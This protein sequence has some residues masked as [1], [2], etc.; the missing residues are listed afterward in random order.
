MSMVH[1][2]LK[3]PKHTKCIAFDGLPVVTV[4]D[5]KNVS[6]DT[7]YPSE[8]AY[9]HYV[10]EQLRV[11]QAFDGWPKGNRLED[12]SK[13]RYLDGRKPDV[14]TFADGIVS[15]LYTLVVGEVKRKK[16]FSSSSKGELATFLERVLYTQPTREKA[17]GFL[18]DGLQ[19]L[20]MLLRQQTSEIPQEVTVT[21]ILDLR[22][23]GDGHSNAIGKRVLMKLLQ[24]KPEVVGFVSVKGVP[25]GYTLQQFIGRGASSTVYSATDSKEAPCAVKISSREQDAQNEVRILDLLSVTDIKAHVP[26]VLCSRGNAIVLEKLSSLGRAE[27]EPGASHFRQ[28]LA[29]LKIAHT[30]L[31]LCHRDVRVSNW[32]LGGD[33]QTRLVDWTFACT[34]SELCPYQGTLGYGSQSV[35]QAYLKNPSQVAVTPADD[36]ESVV[37]IAYYFVTG[38]RVLKGPEDTSQVYAQN[39]L[40][41]WSGVLQHSPV[42]KGYATLASQNDYTLGGL[43][44]LFPHA[45]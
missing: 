45:N 4:G 20:F 9:Q 5:E 34:E 21:P 30:Q 24:S 14:S 26:A 44:D 22:E 42:W 13:D 6:L 37:R 23:S 7:D 39:S 33:D 31:K 36:L 41:F 38:K 3:V 28:L 17:V 29:V 25:D 10:M 16:D 15:S 35:L 19:I 8:A 1:L 27:R 12:T 32:M 18:T 2:S 11:I 43:A 40:S